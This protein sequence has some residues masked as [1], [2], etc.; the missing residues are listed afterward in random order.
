MSE[1][2]VVK[3]R[4]AIELGVV[5][6]ALAIVLI[7]MT[8]GVIPVI[9]TQAKLVNVGLG[10]TYYPAGKL[11]QGQLLVSNSL[12]VSG[13]VCNTGSLTA[14]NAK[15]HILVTDLAPNGTTV[16][17]IN[18]YLTIGNNYPLNGIVDGLQSVYV[19]SLVSYPSNVSDTGT[20]TI[21]PTWTSSL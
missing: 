15:L 18:T 1:K 16:T 13:W 21:T 8:F 9:S 11:V 19:N 17:V 3:R 2:K 12:Q 14:Y 20:W 5:I 7:L 10:G 6:A 4:V